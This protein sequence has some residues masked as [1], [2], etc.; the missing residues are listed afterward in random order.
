MAETMSDPVIKAHCNKC[1]PYIN[2]K[3][4]HKE[5]RR[6]DD[7]DMRIDGIDIYRLLEC[8][9]CEKLTLRHDS[10]NSYETDE[11]GH[12]IEK[13]VY[14]PPAI[15]RQA[16]PWLSSVEGPFFLDWDNPIPR[17]LRE[18]YSAVQNNMP[19]LATMG[20][21]ALMERVMVEKVGDTG[22]IGGN[23][24]K[25][26]SEGFIAQKSVPLFREFLIESGHAAM[27]RAYFPKSSDIIALLDIAESIVEAIYVHPY[28]A[29]G[30]AVPQRKQP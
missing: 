21:R 23:I 13:I 15:S 4:L 22:T 25:F 20:I 18:I 26:I 11:Q 1:G 28:S 6:W 9:G 8:C 17:L 27:H 10:W 12:S 3:V 19:A 30:R 5:E 29:N 14:Y 7:D 24:T 2:H 16:P